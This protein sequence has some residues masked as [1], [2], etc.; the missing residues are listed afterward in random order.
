MANT[1]HSEKYEISPGKNLAKYSE[2]VNFPLYLHYISTKLNERL[3]YAVVD[4][5][6]FVINV[7]KFFFQFF[8]Y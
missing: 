3:T 1:S 6:K 5:S 7:C 4:K 8:L 2:L